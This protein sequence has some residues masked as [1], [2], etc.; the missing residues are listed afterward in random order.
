MCPSNIKNG[1]NPD[2]MEETFTSNGRDQS[3]IV[4]LKLRKNLFY[5]HDVINIF[6]AAYSLDYTVFAL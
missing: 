5:F 2:L 6:I 3:W 4:A 1:R